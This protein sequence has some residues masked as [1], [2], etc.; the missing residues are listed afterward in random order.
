[1]DRTEITNAIKHATAMKVLGG[2]F[3]GMQLSEH[4]SWG[5]GDL[6]PK[7]LGVYEEELHP[8]FQEVSSKPYDVIV[9]VGCAEGYYAVGCALKF[10][11]AVVHAF[12]SN[13]HAQAVCRENAELNGV[14]GRVM[15][16]GF[17]DAKELN[18]ISSRYSR[19]LGIIDCEG[20]ERALFEG[21][22]PTPCAKMDL[23]IECHDAMSP[24]TTP[25]LVS[26]LFESHRIRFVYA[27][28]R[29]P[30]RFPFLSRFSD[31]DRWMS[32][33][34]SRAWLMHWMVCESKAAA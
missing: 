32:I 34:E 33:C 9:D 16:R 29:N 15:T 17:C 26:R 27:S 23:V 28:G 24:G 6:A 2:P 30:N 22:D 18:D 31:F 7:L 4:I 21:D 1:M 25:Y 8:F 13:A 12:D 20:G 3:A 11:N 14:S 5:D 10:A 19:S